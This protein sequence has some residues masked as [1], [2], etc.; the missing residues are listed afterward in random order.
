MSSNYKNVDLRI[1]A[2]CDPCGRL[3]RV[4]SATLS[5]SEGGIL[6]YVESCPSCTTRRP[7]REHDVDGADQEE[8]KRE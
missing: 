2:V 1:V 4:T 5:Q 6:V 3:L 7:V 8:V